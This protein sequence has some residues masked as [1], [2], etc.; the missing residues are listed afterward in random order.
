MATDVTPSLQT[1]SQTVPQRAIA[2]AWHTL[3]LIA[4]MLTMSFTGSERMATNT[5]RPHGRLILYVA[6]IILDWVIV[7]YIWMGLKRRGVRL[8]DVIGGE[9]KSPEDGWLDFAIAVG[10]W[11]C[12]ALILALGKLALGLASLDMSKTMSEVSEL[13]KTLGFIV[14]Q[15]GIEMAAFVAL[16]MTAGFCEELIY[17][18]YFQQQFRAW[19]KNVGLAIAAQGILFGAS[20]GYQGWRFMV[21]IAVYG[22]LFGIMASWRKSLRPG[23]MAH[24]WQDLFSGIA[25]KLAMKLAP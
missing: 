13:K 21:L 23:M 16:T 20:H 18:G 15:G 4:A 9:W 2:P 7:G 24:A 1:P 19:T 8:R 22:C 14:P 5:A 25:L 6:T 10:F 11:I 12:S 3:I 17:R